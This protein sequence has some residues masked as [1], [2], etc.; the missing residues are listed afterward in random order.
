MLSNMSQH[1]MI[2]C[3]I[4]CFGSFLRKDTTYAGVDVELYV[5]KG[6]PPPKKKL[7]IF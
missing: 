6:D 4:L 7:N 2:F 3:L 5:V 1:V